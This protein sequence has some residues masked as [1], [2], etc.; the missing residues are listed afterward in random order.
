M[1]FLQDTPNDFDASAVD[2]FQGRLEAA[3]IRIEQVFGRRLPG[4]GTVKVGRSAHH[5]DTGEVG[6]LLS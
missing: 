2:V 5:N 1:P 4:V 6:Q 3:R